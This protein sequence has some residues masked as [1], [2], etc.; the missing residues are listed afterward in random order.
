MGAQVKPTDAPNLRDLA[1]QVMGECTAEKGTPEYLRECTDLLME[2]CLAD[3]QV[4]D[5][6]LMPLLRQGCYEVVRGLVRETRS[7]VYLTR[8]YDPGGK[9][10]RIHNLAQS[11]MAWP[12]PGGKPLGEATIDDL[13]PA[14]EFYGRQAEQ[15]RAMRDWLGRIAERLGP[16]QKVKNALTEAELDALRT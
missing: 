10:E 8:G 14:A 11:L 3:E 15:M 1:R 5:A 9:S 16:R 7:Q 12:L 6:V 4:R 2:Y 13:I